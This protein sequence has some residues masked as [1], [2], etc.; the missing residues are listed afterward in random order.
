MDYLEKLFKQH[1]FIYFIGGKYYAFGTNACY[2]CD[3]SSMLLDSRY[4]K[5][6]ESVN[7]ELTQKEAW[8]IFHKIIFEADCVRKNKGFCSEPRKEILSFCFEENDMCELKRQ[9]QRYIDYYKKYSLFE[10]Y[11]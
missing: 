1:P 10:F 3:N 4:K 7:Q 5:F 9:V 6:E 2:E 8:D 11:K